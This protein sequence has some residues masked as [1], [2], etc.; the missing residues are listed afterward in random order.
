MRLRER[1]AAEEVGL[2]VGEEDAQ[3][4][5]GLIGPS[6]AWRPS[7]ARSRAE[8]AGRCSRRGGFAALRPRRGTAPGLAAGRRHPQ[9]INRSRGTFAT[10]DEGNRVARASCRT[11]G[12]GADTLGKSARRHFMSRATWFNRSGFG[13]ASAVPR[14]GSS[15]W[16]RGFAS[17]SSGSRTGT[18]R[19]ASWPWPGAC[20]HC[21]PAG[22]M[23]GG[24]AQP[25]AGRCGAPH[26]GRMRRHLA[27]DPGSA[28]PTV[29]LPA[30]P[31]PPGLDAIAPLP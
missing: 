27:V 30:R 14:A 24:S 19:P 15:A 1:E 7:A 2:G 16:S 31:G 10:S 20:S 13:Q 23:T 12:V 8:R 3:R 6:T 22:S 9:L 5:G 17:P 18:R 28:R 29:R 4:P 26:T 11:V 25:W 21:Q